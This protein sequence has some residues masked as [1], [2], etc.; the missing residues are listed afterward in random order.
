M[1]LQAVT[2]RAVTL[3]APTLTHV[4]DAR[5]AVAVPVEVGVTTAGSRRVIAITGGTVTAPA[6]PAGSCPAGPITRPSRA[7]G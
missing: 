1:T 3:P 4:F 6:S 5:I 7:T 2:L